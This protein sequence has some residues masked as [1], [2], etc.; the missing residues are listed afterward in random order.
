MAIGLMMKVSIMLIVNMVFV[1]LRFVPTFVLVLML[2]LLMMIVMVINVLM[3]LVS[4]VSIL[5]FVIVT[6]FHSTSA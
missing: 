5:V 6:F 2:V 1:L 4:I 3:R